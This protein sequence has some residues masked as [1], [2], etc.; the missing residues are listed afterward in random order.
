[1][2][3]DDMNGNNEQV[4]SAKTFSFINLIP[5]LV[6]VASLAVSCAVWT[7]TKE[8]FD[9]VAEERF[10]SQV[11]LIRSKIEGRMLEYEQVLRSGVAFHD[12]SNEVSR[13]EWRQYISSCKTHTWF[14]GIQC[15]GVSVPIAKQDVADFEKSIQQ[16]G[17]SEFKIS[18][19]GDR[20]NYTAIKFVEPFDW[21]NQ[22]SFG[23]DMYSNPIRREAMDR[24]AETGLPSISGKITLVQ[25]TDD[26]VQFGVLCYLPLYEKGASIQT[27]AE[28]KEALT[29]WVYAAFRFNN[30][31]A[32]ILGEHAK[33]LRLRIYDTDAATAKHILFDSR[34]VKQL[35]ESRNNLLTS[36]VPINLSGRI[37]TMHLDA[38]PD[39]LLRPESLISHIVGVVGI[40]TSTL[41]FILLLSF[42][43]QRKRAIE[44]ARQMTRGLVE[45][46][47]KTRSILENASEAILSVSD[48]GQIHDANR[49]AH[50]M[51]A[52]TSSLVDASMDDFLLETNFDEMAN[53]CRAANGTAFTICRKANGKEFQC[54][55]SMGEFTLANTL[56]YIVVIKDETLRISAAEKLAEKNKQLVLAS[57]N[58]GMAEVATGVLHNVGNVLNSVNVSTTIL[59]EKLESRTIS[60]LNKGVDL[61]SQHESDL[62]VF[63]TENEQGKQFPKFVR[64]ITDALISE[65]D[66]EL[67][68]V[69]SLVKSV[70]HIRS[71]VTAQQ[72]SASRSRIAEPIQLA[73][74]LDSAIKMNA[75]LIAR[76]QVQLIT[77]FGNLPTVVSEHHPILQ[78]LINLIKNAM[79]ACS[80]QESSIVSV[81][82]AEES[83]CVRIDV[84]DNGVGISPEQ[85]KSLF[86]H[87][88]TTK[89]N[90]HGFGL[91]ASAI[92]ATELGGSLSVYSDGLGEG[93]AFTLRIPFTQDKSSEQATRSD[94]LVIDNMSDSICREILQTS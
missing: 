77:N 13:S 16:E 83:N 34:T 55:F 10:A 86:Q 56:H 57:R 94:I 66:A 62:A 61:L 12:S 63:L 91:H 82:T 85:T 36:V 78:I 42:T 5:H 4:D 19:P 59:K 8:H 70:D 89:P 38:Q 52:A 24:A 22:R 28:R 92:T 88:F 6:F 71:I 44:L 45:S 67:S 74:L 90:G 43:R 58:A 15:I 50:T 46:E 75:A 23:Y 79:E 35:P 27:V 48:I 21:R 2:N 84:A 32:G 40:L 41:L 29:G 30:L 31:M 33:D 25:E 72:S 18:P 7:Q 73:T 9:V 39:S 49:A 53:R 17:F 65:R 47:Q 20:N 60:I 51:F 14:P 68:E 64:Q 80:D 87:G 81:T 1:M 69:E 11:A 37:W 3:L 54:G 26:D 93:A 76:H